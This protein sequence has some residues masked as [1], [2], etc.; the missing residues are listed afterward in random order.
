MNDN[1]MGCRPVQHPWTSAKRTYTGV[2]HALLEC[3]QSHEE[4]N[5]NVVGIVSGPPH[6]RRPGG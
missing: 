5:L 4:Q 3:L 1:E 2:R 6:D